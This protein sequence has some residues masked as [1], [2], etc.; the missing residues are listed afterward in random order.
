MTIPHSLRP[1]KLLLLSL[2]TSFLIGAA[3]RAADAPLRKDDPIPV[4]GTQGGFDF[5]EVDPAAA[6][7][8][9]PHAG[10]GTLDVIDLATGKLRVS[11]PTGK[12][13]GVA[14]DAQ[15][16]AYY[17]SVSKETKLVLV[18]AASA[19]VTGEVPLPGPADVMAFDPKN[20]TAYIGHDDAAEVWA[21]DV[22][23]RRVVASI[24][25]PEGPE[26]IVYDAVHDR[27][28]ANSKSGNL[29]VVVDPAVNKP[30]ASWPTA[31]A[32]APHG[33]ALDAEG[34]RLFVAGGNGKLVAIDLSSGKVVAT[35]D[36]APGVDQIAYDPALKRVY[37]A[38]GKGTLS[39][40]DASSGLSPLGDVPTQPGVHSVAVDPQSHAVW[41]A[42]ATDR[43]GPAYVQRL[44]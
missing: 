11:I 22:K 7:L 31:P 6:V 4:A 39:V 23:A 28:Y 2:A 16:K 35:A 8:L 27:V 13:Q 36:M 18:D 26:A 1:P 5:L 34:N 12:A 42:Y 17:V 37:C 20:G 29:V 15:A 14:V 40:L 38:S 44:R 24:P 43:T 3:A 21:V 10:N 41:I 19:K 32:Q 33:S 30:I 9:C 25:L